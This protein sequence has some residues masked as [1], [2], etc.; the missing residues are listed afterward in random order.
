MSLKL[1]WVLPMACIGVVGAAFFVLMQSHASANAHLTYAHLNKIQKRLISEPLATALGAGAGLQSHAVPQSGGGN[2]NGGAGGDGLPVTPPKSFQSTSGG[3]STLN[4]FPSSPGGCSA[5]LGNDVKVNQICLNLT[6]ANL[7]GRGQANNEPSISV[8]P[9]NS[10]DLVASDNN[11]IRGDGTCGSY[12]SVNGGRTWT[13]TTIPNGFTP[14]PSGL[15]QRQYWQAGGDTS[16]AWDTRGNAYESCQAFNRG[17][18][19]T[20]NPDL[21]STFL[22]FRA[23]QNKGASWN[24]PG[25]YSTPAVF[26]PTG[27]TGGAMLVDKAL[28]AIDDN[29]NSS[30]RDRI[31][32]T[33]TQ[34]AADGSAYIYEVHSSDYGQTFS[35]PVVVSANSPLCTNTFGAQTPHGNCNENQFSDPFIGPDGSLYVVWANY[36]NATT[37]STDNRNQMLLAKSTDGGQTFS[38]PV[39]VSDYYDLPDCDTYQGDSADP[40]RACVPEK[41]SS[42]VS[43]FRA[44]NYPSGEVDPRHPNVVTVTFGSYINKDSNESNGC[45]PAGL[46]ADGGNRYT[47]VK[48]LG[49]CA[50]KILLSVSTNGGTSFTGTTTD[51][52]NE[53]LVTQSPGQRH[54]DQFWQWSAST[55]DGRLAVDYYDRQYGNDETTG[56]SDFSLS[57]SDDL[58]NFGQIRLTSS[59]MPAPTQFE[60]PEGG[61]FYGDYV[62]LSASDKAYSI[63]S[64]TR[65]RDVFLCP[66]TATTGTPPALCGATEPNGLTANDEETYMTAT[67]VPTAGGRGH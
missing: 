7:Q 42:T 46:A 52:R 43:V 6:D 26:D 12:F 34:Y 9:F 55:R 31:Y 10:Q 17:A 3:T 25:H 30:F 8:N 63:W 11:Y 23:T 14:G 50:N 67:N 2:D 64:D 61:Q 41:G 4:Y 29:V 36:N 22:V 20:T 37:S 5:N 27:A 57:G 38:A 1:R 60:G 62:W 54:T 39:K 15:P 44:T 56:S 19:P 66:G 21:S 51:P 47:G 18:P 59:S 53:T 35:A 24:F 58:T 28:M 45:V 65:A 16:V 33:W 13:N 32:V 40:G 48:V 49:A